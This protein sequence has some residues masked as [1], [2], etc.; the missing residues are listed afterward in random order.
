[1][2][3]SFFASAIKSYNWE[4][5]LKSLKSDFP[6]EVVF[7]SFFDKG[8]L[9]DLLQGYP[10]KYPELK[11]IS[12]E[13]LKIAQCYEIARRNCTGELICWIDDDH[14]F[15]EG[16]AEKVYNYWKSL[17]DP[18]AIVT[19]NYVEKDS[20]E[21]ID[22][23]RFYG[24]NMNTPQMPMCGIMSR[25]YLD[26][27]GGLDSR[28]IKGRWNCDI[29]MRALA[30]GG[31]VYIC[32]DATVHMDSS[33]KN[34][35]YN[36]FWSGWNEDSEQVENSWVIGGYERFSDPLIVIGCSPSD[37]QKTS[38]IVPINNREVTLKRND[39]FVPFPE[40]N[41]LKNSTMPYGEWFPQFE[42]E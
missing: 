23:Y 27:L 16:F 34:G 41:L 40:K 33:N 35:K 21:T 25:E 8:I 3:V 38:C 42:E 28:Y 4:K 6:Y 22:D 13:N 12:V 10:E 31:K 37:E 2:K 18:K 11:Y 29:A 24:R 14:T 26:K 20:D 30:D 9:G 5:V 17:N 39:E 7:C 15:S 32:R 36:N 1:M 19:T